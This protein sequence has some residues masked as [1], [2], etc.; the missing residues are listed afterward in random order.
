MGVKQVLANVTMDEARNAT[1]FGDAQS[2]RGVAMCAAFTIGTVMGGRR[3]RSLTAI[4]LR[5]FRLF[6][7]R[8]LVDDIVVCPPCISITF[9]EE[10]YDDI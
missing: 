1:H 5:D 9:R 6:V 7:G 2:V 4:R 8:V 3:P 10:K